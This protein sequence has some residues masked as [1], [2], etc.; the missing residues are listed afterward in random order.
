MLTEYNKV[1]EQLGQLTHEQ[2]NL[3]KVKE[4]SD[5]FSDPVKRKKH[6]EDELTKLKTMLA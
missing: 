4:V 6:Y 5:K 2:D 1:K 3:L